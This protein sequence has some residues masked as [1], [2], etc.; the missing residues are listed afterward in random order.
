METQVEEKNICV[1]ELVDKSEL[2]FKI[3]GV[4]NDYESLEYDSPPEPH[5]KD[6]IVTLIS[7]KF[8]LDDYKDTYTYAKHQYV[9]EKADGSQFTVTLH[10]FT[11]DCTHASTLNSNIPRIS[12]MFN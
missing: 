5:V 7:G 10:S 11:Y 4:K 1:L 9:F 6:E 12:V 3:I 8:P 2:K